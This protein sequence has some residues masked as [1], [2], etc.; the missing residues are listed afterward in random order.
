ML[1]EYSIHPKVNTDWDSDDYRYHQTISVDWVI[2]IDGAEAW[3][4]TAPLEETARTQAETYALCY[5]R[6]ALEEGE[7]T[8]TIQRQTCYNC[9]WMTYTAGAPDF[10]GDTEDDLVTMG[11][12]CKLSNR[13]MGCDGAPCDDWMKGDG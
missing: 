5:A 12:E 8:I 6:I 7:E 4:G 1:L 10:A 9:N 11:P 3:R 2:Y 13:E